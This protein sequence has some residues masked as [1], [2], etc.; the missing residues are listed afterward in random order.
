MGTGSGWR[1]HRRETLHCWVLQVMFECKVTRCGRFATT[2]LQGCL[3]RLAEGKDNEG[4][5]GVHW[6]PHSW[7]QVHPDPFL[8]FVSTFMFFVDQVQVPDQGGKRVRHQR[9]ESGVRSVWCQ[10]ADR[11]WVTRTT[12]SHHEHFFLT[13]KIFRVRRPTT[14]S[15]RSK[16]SIFVFKTIFFI[17]TKNVTWAKNN[18]NSVSQAFMIF[19]WV[20]KRV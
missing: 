12:W 18:A 5:P 15:C 4:M 11:W 14:T 7:F 19:A 10:P 13:I 1:R 9:R 2:H 16:V 20:Q 6:G 3:G 17:Q 8:C